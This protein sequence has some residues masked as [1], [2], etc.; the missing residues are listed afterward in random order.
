MSLHI[1]FDLLGNKM[2]KSPTVEIEF[3]SSVYMFAPS[4][5][6][7]FFSQVPLN[8]V[9]PVMRIFDP[10]YTSKFIRLN[11]NSSDFFYSFHSQTF[12]GHSPP[13]HSLEAVLG[14]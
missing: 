8:P 1:I 12:H 9:P 4:I 14:L 6:R 13:S 3:I 11:Q 10:E 7:I 5:K 2:P